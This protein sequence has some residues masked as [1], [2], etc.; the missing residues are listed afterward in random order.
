MDSWLIGVINSVNEE[1]RE[2][3]ETGGRMSVD[4]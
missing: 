1:K 2:R 3:G 4:A